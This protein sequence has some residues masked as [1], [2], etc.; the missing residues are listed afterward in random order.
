MANSIKRNVLIFDFSNDE[1]KTSCPDYYTVT[2][3]DIPF[4]T[5]DTFTYN[6]KNTLRSGA[7]KDKGT[8]SVQINFE[9]V[10]DG[11]IELNYCVSSEKTYDKMYIYVDGAEQLVK[12]GAIEWTDFSKDLSVGSHTL[13]VKYTK[14]GSGTGGSDACAIG[15]LMITGVQPI[16]IKYIIKSEDTLYTVSD[17]VLTALQETSLNSSLFASY[18]YNDFP[19]AAL[20]IGLTN[21][22]IFYW[23][24]STMGFPDYQVNVTAIPYPQTVIT[25]DIDISH[26]TV[27]G[28]AS[29]T[30][31][32]AGTPMFA[33]EFNG[34]WKEYDGTAWVDAA[35][36]MTFEALTAITTE[37]WTE[38]INGLN[39]FKIK[40]TLDDIDDKVTTLM[41]NFAVDVSQAV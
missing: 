17:G 16:N 6:G 21:P 14:D 33:C 23:S 38:A 31:E 5:N 18:G 27:V 10:E 34:S 8:T 41:V 30:G 39:S 2:E 28:I 15:K 37:R 29:V 9:L 19:D 1:W 3:S 11:K 20:L 25:D 40:F 24:D 22:E 36:G 4:F 12:S 32:C 35:S 7:I 26:P 13:L